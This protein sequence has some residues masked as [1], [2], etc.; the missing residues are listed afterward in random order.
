MRCVLPGAWRSRSR[1]RGEVAMARA[2]IGVGSN[3][4]PEKNVRAA[5]LCLAQQ[6]RLIGISMVYRTEALAHPEQPPYFNCVVEV[7]TGA[8]PAQVKHAILH[9]IETSLGRMRTADKYAPRTIDLDLIL[10]GDLVINAPDVRL[11]DPEILERP[12]LAIPL[13]ELAP[14]LVL[15]GFNLRISEVAAR[16]PRGGMAPL[17]G[18]A[19]RLREEAGCGGSR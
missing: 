8:L 10:Y 16:L 7:E 3:I 19:V 5:I 18:Y 6:I 12:F 9:P 17:E 1:E 2:F 4:E 15:P 11:P 14:D 13:F